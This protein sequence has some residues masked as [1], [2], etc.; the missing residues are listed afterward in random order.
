MN[1]TAIRWSGL[2]LI[3]GGALFAVAVGRISLNPVVGQALSPSNSLFLLGAA[4][5][6]LVGLPG[7]YARHAAAAGSL[8]FAGFALLEAGLVL[9]VMVASTPILYPTLK[10]PTSEHPVLFFL[11]VALVLGLV[12]T[13]IATL[14]ARV[15]PSWSG[16]LLIAATAGFFFSF[17]I[18]EFLPPSAG[19]VGSAFFGV[20]LGLGLTWAGFFMWTRP[21]AP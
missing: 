14:Q 15:F 9:V 5:L 20:V 12:L 10:V 11:G 1:E 6:L 4:V 8:G 16:L 3:G 21:V 19:Q 18:A 2:L 13:S 17:F 7:M